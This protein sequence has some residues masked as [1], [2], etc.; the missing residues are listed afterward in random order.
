MRRSLV[1][2]RKSYFDSAL[3]AE[4]TGTVGQNSRRCHSHGV[5]V[6]GTLR[7]WKEARLEREVEGGE[8]AGVL[9]PWQSG[10]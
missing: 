5:K 8:V 1:I 2:L 7:S 6:H 4:A 3:D 10:G 9:S